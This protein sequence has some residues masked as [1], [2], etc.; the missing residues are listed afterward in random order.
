MVRMLASRPR[1]LKRT[2]KI[3]VTRPAMAPAT[4]AIA[5]AR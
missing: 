5:V 4:M 2:F 1:I 3:A